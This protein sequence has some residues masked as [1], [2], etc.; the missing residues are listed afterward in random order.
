MTDHQEIE[1][2]FLMTGFPQ[3]G[4]ELKHLSHAMVY[5]SYLGLDPEVRIRRKVEGDKVKCTLTIKGEGTLSRTEVELPC[6]ESECDALMALCDG[7]P[8]CKDFHCYALGD[9]GLVLEVSRVDD[10]FCYAEVEFADQES[11]LAWQVP[12]TVA[13]YVIR[14]T[15][16]ETGFRMKHYWKEKNGK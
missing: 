7:Q 8:A 14:E 2:K 4:P 9:S 15:T 12:P 10:A 5:Q 1:R 13:P 11:A 6:S 16:Q 3:A